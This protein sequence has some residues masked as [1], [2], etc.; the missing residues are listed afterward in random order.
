MPKAIAPVLPDGTKP[1]TIEG[2][3]YDVRVRVGGSG[4]TELD[5]QWRKQW[6]KDQQLTHREPVIDRKMIAQRMNPIRR[7]LRFPMDYLFYNVLEPKIGYRRA[8]I[9]RNMFTKIVLGMA[10]LEF[11]YYYLKY[12]KQNWTSLQG[13]HVYDTRPRI[14]PGEPGY[15]NFTK[16]QPNDYYDK[17]FKNSSFYKPVNY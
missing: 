4:M 13:W 10:F 7:F 9:G 6:V 11:A 3:T 17:G 5:R 1:M 2:P 14:L 12:E 8:F 15:P 16:K